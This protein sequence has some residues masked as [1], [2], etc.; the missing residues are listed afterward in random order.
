MIADVFL[1]N[2]P[3]LLHGLLNF[4]TARPPDTLIPFSFCWP[5][6]HSLISASHRQIAISSYHLENHSLP[7]LS[8]FAPILPIFGLLNVLIDWH[9]TLDS[10]YNPIFTS[11]HY[12]IFEIV[13]MKAIANHPSF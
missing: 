2:N 9:T 8:L 10:A 3:R 1:N 5:E 4:H 13:L 12:P 11:R 6:C 7:V